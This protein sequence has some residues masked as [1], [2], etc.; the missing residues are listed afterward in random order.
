MK[1]KMSLCLAGLAM[2]VTVF[3]LTGCGGTTT[4]ASASSAAS[5]AAASSVASSAAGDAK[6]LT[7]N[8]ED[9]YDKV[10]Y[11]AKTETDVAKRFALMHKA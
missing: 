1:K 6:V 10:V 7:G 11:A 2:V 3:G 5:S 4:S 9:T 8:W